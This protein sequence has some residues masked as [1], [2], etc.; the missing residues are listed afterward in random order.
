MTVAPT[1]TLALDGEVVIRATAGL[2]TVTVTR[3]ILSSLVAV[4]VA[5]PAA[6]ALMTPVE[7][8]VAMKFASELQETVRPVRTL[9]EASL[10][11]ATT[12]ARPSAVE[13]MTPTR[14]ETDDVALRVM[15]ATGAG[16]GAVTEMVAVAFFPSLSAVIIAVPGPW[17]VTIPELLTIATLGLLVVQVIVRPV[18]TLLDA[19]R[20]VGVMTPVTPT[21]RVRLD[22]L[23]VMYAT[24]GDTYTEA[25][26]TAPSL[27]AVIVAET[28]VIAPFELTT[29]EGLDEDQ[30]TLRPVSTL[31]CASYVT[32]DSGSVCPTSRFAD[33]GFIAT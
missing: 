20:S 12:V 23:S 10:V 14:S 22:G 25:D 2:V 1:F 28:A 32:A 7:L 11:V 33:L 13:S 21:V 4:I 17:P 31:L 8:T 5:L 30:L 6:T 29:T 3:A 18:R 15:D 16:G 27:V 24:G 19:S 26:P 9:P